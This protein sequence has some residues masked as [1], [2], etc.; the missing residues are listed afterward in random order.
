MVVRQQPDALR[1]PDLLGAR[2]DARSEHYRRGHVAVVD[3]VM[4]CKPD[5]A[6]VERFQMLDEFDRFGIEIGPC[7]FPLRRVA[8]VEAI[9]EAKRCGHLLVS[10]VSCRVG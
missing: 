7:P 5:L 2:G 1:Y 8:H 3:A 9:T 6:E 10:H 4:L